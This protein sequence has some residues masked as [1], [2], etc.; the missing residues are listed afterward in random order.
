MGCRWGVPQYSSG[1]GVGLAWSKWRGQDY[2]G[3][4]VNLS[5]ITD[6]RLGTDQWAKAKRKAAIEARDTA[7]ELLNLYAQRAAR[8]GTKIDLDETAYERFVLEF[9]FEETEDQETA[10]A[11]VLQDLASGRPMDRVSNGWRKRSQVTTAETG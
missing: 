3:A 11:N 2:H 8:K 1:R 5:V 7:A 9:P 6:T 4:D 10:I